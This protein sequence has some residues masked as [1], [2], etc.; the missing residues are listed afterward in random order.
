VAPDDS[1]PIWSTGDRAL[2]RA[3]AEL[4]EAGEYE[5]LAELL[6]RAAH[7]RQGEAI[8]AQTLDL[9][10]R[11]CLAC[12]QSQAEA[13]WHQQ[14]RAEAAQ[15]EEKLR[16]QLDALLHLDGEGDRSEAAPPP[17]E[18]VEPL[19]LR[20]RLNALLHG[21]PRPLDT[22][23]PPAAAPA[24]KAPP[25][26]A[27]KPEQET[28][29]VPR[30]KPVMAE[31]PGLPALPPESEE[32]SSA[33]LHTQ[34]EKRRQPGASSSPP[35]AEEKK[36]PGQ[37]KLVIHCLGPFRVYSNLNLID[38]W[39]G[40]RCK[41]LFKYLIFHRRS[42]VHREVLMELFWPD[43][44]PDAAIRNLY[45]A[46]YSLRKA[47]KAGGIAFP[48]ILCEESCYELNPDLD[49]WIDSEAFVSHHQ[50]GRQLEQAG[51]LEEAIREYELADSLYEG[52]FLSEDRYEDWPVIERENLKHTHLDVL[53]RLSRF[54]FEQAHFTMCITFCQKIVAEDNCREDIHR[55]LMRCFCNCNQVHLAIRQYHLCVETLKRELD[56]PPMPA[57]IELYRQI[58]SSRVQIQSP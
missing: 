42:P 18:P 27:R 35:E 43:A 11:I 16:L 46:V 10:R 57:T 33:I 40:Q 51:H 54:Y 15:R 47:L 30:D 13:K 28:G 32:I 37:P 24:A 26:P 56:V 49:L 41:A 29:A 53:D 19:S 20:Q 36:A 44:D 23:T 14:A 3:A 9:A 55:R 7:D 4:L 38:E 6:E 8:P 1:T 2:V 5:R 39:P 50:S 21:R 52:E 34:P 17:P 45:Q 58:R 31:E 22:E 25:P 48:Y 12:S